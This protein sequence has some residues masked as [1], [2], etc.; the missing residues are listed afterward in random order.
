M[1]GGRSAGAWV[2]LSDVLR[3]CFANDASLLALC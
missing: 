3:I 1:D 2:A